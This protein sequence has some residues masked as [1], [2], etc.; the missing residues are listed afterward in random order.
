MNLPFNSASVNLFSKN[1]M[2]TKISGL[3]GFLDQLIATL[4]IKKLGRF[5][6]VVICLVLFVCL[7]LFN[8]GFL[9]Y[10]YTTCPTATK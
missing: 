2:N 3:N 4:S 10:L 8:F 5:A 9:K 6:L 7:F 1:T